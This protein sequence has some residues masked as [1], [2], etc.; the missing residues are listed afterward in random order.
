VLVTPRSSGSP[1]RVSAFAL[2]LFYATQLAIP[3]PAHPGLILGQMPTARNPEFEAFDRAMGKLLSVSHDELKRRM[4][5]YKVEADKN[6]K[7]RGPKKMV[8]AGKKHG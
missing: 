1:I 5:A 2:A 3:T 7:K 6:P 8:K 4:E